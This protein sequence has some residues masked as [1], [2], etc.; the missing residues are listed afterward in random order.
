MGNTQIVPLGTSP[1][2][3]IPEGIPRGGAPWGKGHPP[4]VPL[5]PGQGGRLGPKMYRTNA[6]QSPP[7]KPLEAKGFAPGYGPAGCNKLHQTIFALDCQLSESF[8][9]ILPASA[10][11]TSASGAT[12]SSVATINATSSAATSNAAACAT[13]STAAA[14]A[15]ATRC[16]R[17]AA[18]V[19]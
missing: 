2:G 1:L 11:T 7:G 13:A 18:W 4:W 19:Q 12:A 17:L 16:S 6:M 3:A 8:C 10:L 9:H 5:P 14:F 15:T